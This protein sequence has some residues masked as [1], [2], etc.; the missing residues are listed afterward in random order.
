MRK[1]INKIK[2]WFNRNKPLLDLTKKE[3]TLDYV[4]L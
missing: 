1:L 4:A 2:N 3:A